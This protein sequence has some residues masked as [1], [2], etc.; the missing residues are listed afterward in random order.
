[1]LGGC[2]GLFPPY[3]L[4]GVLFAKPYLSAVGAGGEGGRACGL[5]PSLGT[6]VLGAVCLSGRWAQPPP[7]RWER[8][9]GVRPGLRIAAPCLVLSQAE[10]RVPGGRVGWPWAVPGAGDEGRWRHPARGAGATVAPACCLFWGDLSTQRVLAVSD[11]SVSCSPSR[12]WLLV[13][14]GVPMLSPPDFS[15]PLCP[16]CWQGCRERLPDWMAPVSWLSLF[17]AGN[18]V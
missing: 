4:A 7:A 12:G 15:P 17:W 13:S 6:S 9:S 8:R 16:G 14:L 3:Q 5:Q 10:R 11:T 18:S 1:M 2:H